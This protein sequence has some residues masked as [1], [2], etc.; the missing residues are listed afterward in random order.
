MNVGSAMAEVG[1]REWDGG[2]EQKGGGEFVH[3]P[4]SIYS[5][6]FNCGTIFCRFASIADVTSKKEN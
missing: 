6:S 1:W 2:S 4:C 3:H 5:D